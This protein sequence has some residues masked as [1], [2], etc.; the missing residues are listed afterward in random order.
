[1]STWVG[2]SSVVGAGSLDGFAVGVMASGAFFLALTAPR[3]AHS[4]QITAAGAPATVGTRPS[5][6]LR[7]RVL[8]SRLR[9]RQAPAGAFRSSAPAGAFGSGQREPEAFGVGG[10][11]PEAFGVGGWEP[12]AIGVGGWEPGAI[13][14]RRLRPGVLEFGSFGLRPFEN[15]TPE[16]HVASAAAFGAGASGAGAERVAQ[17]AETGAHGERPW[18][19]SPAAEDVDTS[20]Y[21]EP[22]RLGRPFLDSWLLGSAFPGGRLPDAGRVGGIPSPGGAFTDK[23]LGEG[24]LR[25]GRRQAGASVPDGPPG[26]SGRL[27]PLPDVASPGTSRGGGRRGDPFGDLAFPDDSFW[28]SKR[29]VTRRLPR[30]AAPAAGLGSKVSHWVA[31]LFGDRSLAS[32][33]RG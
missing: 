16:R 17:P 30:H 28:P 5:G 24:V 31:G 26:E 3:R 15:V 19:P 7:G 10:W 20:G 1:M 4:R 8:P 23:S 21:R 13:G 22:A 6:W 9:G 32:G 11:E 29:P 27:D 2:V 12:G 33:A 14:V 18:L 25:G